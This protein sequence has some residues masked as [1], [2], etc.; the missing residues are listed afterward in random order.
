[1]QRLKAGHETVAQTHLRYGAVAEEV[2]TLAEEVPS[3]LLR[4]NSNK[5]NNML[6]NRQQRT[7]TC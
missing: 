1:M 3:G 5:S 4:G 7:A 6:Y 2:I